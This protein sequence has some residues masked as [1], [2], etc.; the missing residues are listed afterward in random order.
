MSDTKDQLFSE[1]RGLRRHQLD[2]LAELMTIEDF[3]E[4]VDHLSLIDYDGTGTWSTLTHHLTDPNYWI[5]P[6]HV[7]DG[8]NKP[9]HWATH[10]LWFNR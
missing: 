4:Q 8:R 7:L 3:L 2:D 6:S 10:V 1:I 5:L 9:P